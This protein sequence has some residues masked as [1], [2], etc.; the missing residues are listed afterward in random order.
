MLP[1]FIRYLFI[2]LCIYYSCHKIVNTKTTNTHYFFL[3]IFLSSFIAL[4]SSFFSQHSIILSI[5]LMLILH[6]IFIIILTKTDSKSSLL[7][8]LLSSALSFTFYTI[9]GTFICVIFLML[10]KTA[11]AIPYNYIHLPMGVFQFILIC[12]TFKIKRLRNGICFLIKRKYANIT[13]LFSLSFIIYI[14]LAT[15]T[16]NF[17]TTRIERS[18]VIFLFLLLALFLLYYWNHRITQT[19][20][21][22]LRLAN[23]KALE[24]E[25]TNKT[26]EIKTLK[27][28]NERL[29]KIIHKDN[30]LVPAM[31]MA[32]TDLLENID[33][34]T[35][36]EFSSRGHELSTQLHKMAEDRQGILTTTRAKASTDPQTGIHTVD[37]VLSYM[38]TRAVKENITYK[39]HID[40]NIKPL[41]LSS[42]SEEDLCHLL[43]DL[44]ENAIIATRYSYM[45]KQIKI[46]LGILQNHF[47]LEISDSGR[48]F[49]I[50]TYQYFGHEKHTT[51]AEHGG[52]GIGLI[53][54]WKIK[55]ENKISLQIYEYMPDST[56][57]T[58]KFSFVFDRKNHF[59]MQ[60]YR[61][62]EIIGSLTRGDL[63]VFPYE[64][65]H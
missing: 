14:A 21:E 29:A 15:A 55:K 65:N 11:H 25:L 63:Y 59:L 1:L 48:E 24:D 2:N 32:V 36:E 9:S 31:H 39:L 53:D 61:Y 26:E 28:D 51:H 18:M 22:K 60:T 57:Y 4:I 10:Y 56:A 40:E 41:I 27:A 35:P 38:E 50:E 43:S 17:E 6:Y 19:Y 62:K 42:I 20:K 13:I 5:T 8:V 64:S 34:L 54:I 46:H 44:I 3:S 30:K 33:K 47:M 7:A 37:G 12:T 52:S 49:D 16:K 58:K 45:T 23:E